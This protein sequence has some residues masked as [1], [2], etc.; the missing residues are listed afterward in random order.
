MDVLQRTEA[1]IGLRS[2]Y[3]WLYADGSPGFEAAVATNEYWALLQSRLS[4]DS[5]ELRLYCLAILKL[6]LERLPNT[7]LNI[8][9]PCFKYE[10]ANREDYRAGYETYIT[11]FKAAVLDRYSNQVEEVVSELQSSPVVHYVPQS[12][13]LVLFSSV[14]MPSTGIQE[15]VRKTIGSAV[16]NNRIVTAT[17]DSYYL[18]FLVRAFLPW[19]TQG[20]HFT[21]NALRKE[22]SGIRCMHG[23]L[24]ESYLAKKISAL[25]T[26][27]GP[28][29]FVEAC[30][31]FI[32][33][34]GPKL[35]PYAAMHVLHGVLAGLNALRQSCLEL[36]HVDLAVQVSQRNGLP[37]A[38]RDVCH[39]F[40]FDICQYSKYFPRK[41]VQLL[42]SDI[43]QE[44]ERDLATGS[45][46]F[47]APADKD[48][49]TLKYL[50]DAL[51]QS[52]FTCLK[53]RGLSNACNH[54]RAVLSK[55]ATPD[56]SQL[57]K[58]FDAIWN[59]IEIRDYPK[60]AL[61]DVPSLFFHPSS[62]TLATLETDLRH[63]L[64]GILQNLH[65]LVEGRVYVLAPLTSSLR[66][67]CLAVPST[68]D[69]LPVEDFVVRFA[70][71]PPE[72]RSEFMLEWVAA[73]IHQEY[74]ADKGYSYYYGKSRSYG[75]ACFYDMLNRWPMLGRDAARRIIQRIVEPWEKQKL[76]VPIVSK[77]KN[78][79][80]LHVVLLLCESLLGRS[81]GTTSGNLIHQLLVILSV[82]PL[83]RYRFLLEWMITR[84]YLRDPNAQRHHV[85]TE[86][87]NNDQSNP[88]YLASMLKIASM[89]ARLPDSPESYMFALMT[90]LV[91][92]SSSPK[93]VIRHESQWALPPLWDHAVAKKWKS[94]VDNPAFEALVSYIQTL[95]KYSDPPRERVY[96]RFD[97]IEDH[98]LAT[99]FQGNYLK[100]EPSEGQILGRQDFI[101]VWTDDAANDE[102]SAVVEFP[103]AVVPLGTP[104]TTPSVPQPLPVEAPS[105]PPVPFTPSLAPFQT[106]SSTLSLPLQDLV[107]DASTFQPTHP[108][109]LIASLIDA[110][111]NLGG[112][113]RA[114]EIFGCESL[115]IPSLS[116]LS[117]NAFTSVSV[118]SHLHIP[119]AALPP[120][121]LPIFFAQKK[122]E[123]YIIVGVEQTDRSLVLGREGAELPK[124]CVLVMGAERTGIPGEVL[125]WCDVCVEV[126]QVGVTRSL[127]VQ[128]AGSVVLFEYL[129]QWGER[130]ESGVA[131][132]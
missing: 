117:Q 123:G 103:P 124:K 110:P 65:T 34:R 83:P 23:E 77:W 60:G 16:L 130:G 30:L 73:T 79:A 50:L 46:T 51:I 22:G 86:L 45:P 132:G 68:I 74:N 7:N 19:S 75:Y 36:T 11:F 87:A 107:P 58:V 66:R 15:N 17:F 118:S 105:Q 4:I 9:L 33:D 20:F 40:C 47:T 67:A 1:A 62:V 59:E 70:L 78:S 26:E 52:K 27:S 31:Q 131:G 125:V 32:L 113:S 93:I 96:E 81:D 108:V 101:D 94:V 71:R 97:P 84:F 95:P 129:R 100:A 120:A 28:P 44:S 106:K 104:P 122:S 38:A 90:R 119:I 54:A 72:T 18:D 8:E 85:L 111:Q 39:Q 25:A 82:E 57:H 6:T 126:P 24:L 42:R 10:A 89:V 56:P 29:A 53:N 69:I 13:F 35:F 92:L 64:A 112:L 88:K 5:R 98:S 127:N 21:T 14:L 55:S 116:V 41:T 121:E 102:S 80:Q 12:W 115:Q 61:M 37:E 49:P 48:G 76:P 43:A 109:I 63:F 2:W 114:A 99:L 91:V 128:T 3:R